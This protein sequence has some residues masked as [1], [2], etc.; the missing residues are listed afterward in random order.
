MERKFPAH[1]RMTD[2]G[3]MVR[4]YQTR[5]VDDDPEQLEES[6]SSGVHLSEKE[7]NLVELVAR[8]LT[9]REIAKK[10]AVTL[11]T[12][13]RNR[14]AVMRKLELQDRPDLIEYAIRQGILRGDS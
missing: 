2:K 11:R 1:I 5:L 12:V 8:G 9:N 4:A 14:A 10:L 3:K 6:S 7:R 13:E